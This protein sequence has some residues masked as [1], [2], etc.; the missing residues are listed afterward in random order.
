MTITECRV[1]ERRD[2]ITDVRKEMRKNRIAK[3]MVKSMKYFKICVGG[4]RKVFPALKI[5]TAV[6][7][8]LHVERER[9]KARSREIGKKLKLGSSDG[10]IE[11][12]VE[13]TTESYYDECRK[14]E[15]NK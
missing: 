6:K 8:A 9:L 11:I 3:E 10:K 1:C 15:V 12:F 7:M 4:T 5:E 13:E 14:C 2:M